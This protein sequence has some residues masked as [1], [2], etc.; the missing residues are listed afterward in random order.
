MNFCTPTKIIYNDNIITSS[1][2]AILVKT[3]ERSDYYQFSNLTDLLLIIC[4][5]INGVLDNKLNNVISI[6]DNINQLKDIKK[7][8]NI[9][10]S[11]NNEIIFAIEFISPN[12]KKQFLLF[13]NLNNHIYV[14]PRII[15]KYLQYG[16]INKLKLEF[17]EFIITNLISI[18]YKRNLLFDYDKKVY[19]IGKRKIKH[20]I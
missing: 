9:K 11:L 16:S 4:G 19:K 5:I 14:F 13:K 15:T 1:I 18:D 2:N 17:N 7:L 6:G 8:L 20:K 10:N 3:T 12:S